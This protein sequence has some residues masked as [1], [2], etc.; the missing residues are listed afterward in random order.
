MNRLILPLQ[1]LQTL[2]HY[3]D[4]IRLHNNSYHLCLDNLLQTLF[5]ICQLLNN[6]LY[7]EEFQIQITIDQHYLFLL[8][9]DYFNHQIKHH[10]IKT[11]ILSDL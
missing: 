1:C 11:K 7:R 2:D 3:L 8:D 10:K 6:S 9:Q 4:Q 5:K